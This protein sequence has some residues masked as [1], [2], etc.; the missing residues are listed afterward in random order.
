MK[1]QPF[2]ITARDKQVVALYADFLPKRIFDA[3]THLYC[4]EVIP[5]WY[6]PDGIFC[7]ERCTPREYLADMQAFLPGVEQV[8]LNMMPM[9]DPALTKTENGLRN[10]A[11]GYIVEQVKVHPASVGCAYI[12]PMDNGAAIEAMA[13]QPGIRGLKCYAYGAG[14]PDLEALSVGEYLPEVA[15][16]VAA[17]RDIPIILHLMRPAAL[18]DPDNLSYIHQMARRYP[19]AK[20]VLAHCA[21]GFASWTVVDGIRRLEDAGNIWFDMSSICEPSPMM[22]CI[23]QNAGKRTVWGSDYP[24]CLHRGRAVSVATGQH[25]LPELAEAATYIAAENLLA[26]Y[27]AAQLL[28]LDAT[29]IQ[30]IFYNNAATLFNL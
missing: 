11:N 23:L 3:H 26:L 24:I 16:E 6:Q 22:A 8:G 29:Q 30:D 10:R 27:Q 18:S 25:W 14:K 28:D 15:F 13:Y 2:P 12:L 20:L 21:R 19:K 9:P 4:S 5:A 7:R 1:H 17:A